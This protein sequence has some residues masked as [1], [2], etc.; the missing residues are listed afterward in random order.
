MEQKEQKYIITARSVMG[1][2]AS[3]AVQQSPYPYPENLEIVLGKFNDLIKDELNGSFKQ[4][5]KKFE[6]WN[7]C[8]DWISTKLHTIPEFMLW[9]E[10]KNSRQGMGF[11]G[12][13]HN[14][15]GDVVVVSKDPEADDD[16]IDI[17]ALTRNVATAAI[18]D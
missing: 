13:G 18:Q 10:R 2:L 9:N 7:E 14:D 12:A 15:E 1:A 6:N 8:H 4:Y 11:S 17:D 3:Y 16:F 5:I